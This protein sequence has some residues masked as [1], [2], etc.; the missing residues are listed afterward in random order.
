DGIWLVRIRRLVQLALE[1]SADQS[2]RVTRES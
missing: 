2:K 1:I